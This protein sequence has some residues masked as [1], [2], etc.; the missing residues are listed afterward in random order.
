M[1]LQGTLF[2][3]QLVTTMGTQWWRWV[4]DTITSDLELL[5]AKGTRILLLTCR[6]GPENKQLAAPQLQLLFNALLL[7][8][9]V[10]VDVVCSLHGSPGKYDRMAMWNLAEQFWGEHGHRCTMSSFVGCRAGYMGRNRQREV[11]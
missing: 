2:M 9:Q 4:S 11:D 3:P 10:K 6:W 1:D 5:K 7:S 8:L